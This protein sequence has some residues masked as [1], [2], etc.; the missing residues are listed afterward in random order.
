M[1]QLYHHNKDHI[2]VFTTVCGPQVRYRF[3]GLAEKMVVTHNYTPNWPDEVALARG[4]VILVMSKHEEERWFGRLQSGRRGYF[5]ASCVVELG[6]VCGSM[7]SVLAPVLA[8]M[9]SNVT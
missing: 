5:P 6:Q 9:L 2:E 4:D 7:L 1:H 8:P 3:R